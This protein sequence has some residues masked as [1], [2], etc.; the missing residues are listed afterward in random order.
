MQIAAVDIGNSSIKIAVEHSLDDRWSWETIIREPN[1][2]ELD[3]SKLHQNPD[4]VFWSVSSVNQTRAARL[5]AWIAAQRPQDHFHLITP[6]EVDLETAVRSRDRLGRD[7]LIAAWRALQLNESG[8]LV[9][10]D[11]GTAVTIDVVDENSI[12][13]GGII[14]PGA[15]TMLR[16][17]ATQTDALPDLSDRHIDSPTPLN[18]H[19]T[20]AYIGKSTESAILLGVYQTQRCTLLA[21]V[22]ALSSGYSRAPDVYLTGGGAVELL[23]WLPDVWQHVPD[24]V[25]QGARNIGRTLL[26][27]DA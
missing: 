6:S 15:A 9:V 24:L 2:S 17:L 8:P 20:S 11:A 27:T 5:A 4:P 13:Q 3:H 18:L 7:R 19:S 21:A 12:F 25:L 14:F 10:I 1:L 26:G 22:A 16:M 23:E